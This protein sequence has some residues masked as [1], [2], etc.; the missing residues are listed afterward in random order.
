MSGSM[1]TKGRGSPPAA[2]GGGGRCGDRRGGLAAIA[3][4]LGDPDCRLL[5]L[6]GPG[7]VGKT[8]LALEAARR[9]IERHPHGVHFV[10]L[11]PV[12]S[13]EFLVPAVADALQFSVD[14]A[15]SPVAAED[16]L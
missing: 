9:R 1:C 5:T 15:H 6:V 2:P 4:L 11:A 12:A 7:G 13:A 3:R 8:R 10:P 16:Q 14:F